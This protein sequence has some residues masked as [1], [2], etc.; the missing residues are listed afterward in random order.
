M[1]AS[2]T[3]L[4]HST[5]SAIPILTKLPKYGIHD[6]ELAWFTD[7]LFHRKAVV[8]YKQ[9]RSGSFTVTSG[10]PQGSIL[11]PLLFLLLFN[12]L[13]DVVKHA[14]VLKYAEDTVVYNSCKNVKDIS[15]LLSVDLSS[16]AKWFKENELLMNLK[17]DKTEALLFGTSKKPRKTPRTLRFM[18]ISQRSL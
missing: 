6:R 9:A 14:H 2:L 5:P 12:D 8:Q 10:V 18:Q 1:P 11:G 17:Q 13:V 4:K 16:I 15:N 7:Y 3:Y